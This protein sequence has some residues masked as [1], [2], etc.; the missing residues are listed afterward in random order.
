MAE[1]QPLHLPDLY[2]EGF[3][4][5]DK[6]SIPRLGRVTLLA[7]KNGVGKSTVLDAIRV[8]AARGRYPVLRELLEGRDE[9]SIDVDEDGDT[10]FI[11]DIDALFYGWNASRSGCVKIGPNN[12]DFQLRIELVSQYDELDRYQWHNNV[13]DVDDIQT[14]KVTF[15]QFSQV[16]PWG[17][18]PRVRRMS[19]KSEMHLT[20]K[21]ESLGPGVLTNQEIANFWDSVALTDD[22]SLALNSLR[23]VFGNDLSNVAVVGENTARFSPKTISRNRSNERRAIVRLSPYDR[24]VSLRSL[25]DGS[26]RVFGVALALANSRNGFLLIDEVEN[27]IHHSLQHDFWRMVL[28]TAQANNVQVLATT[29]S[30]D[31][32][33]SFARAAIECEESE[34]ILYRLSRRYGEL[35][36]VEYPE[37]ELKIAADQ[38]I[39]VR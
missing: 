22:E 3:L 5:I 35:R 17:L 36:A 25:G 20:V 2:I 33:S 16:I 13:W 14:L 19:A 23:L 9:I 1:T 24:P 11:P 12:D 10:A 34:G 26:L 7:G 39:E 30:R 21:C 28:Q 27:G 4:G 6:L 18:P 8:Y 32:V 38:H 15:R 29:H 37:D 31:C